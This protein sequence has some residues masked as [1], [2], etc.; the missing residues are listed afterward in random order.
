[1]THECQ[2]DTDGDGDCHRCA[3][4]P[5]GCPMTHEA[6]ELTAEELAE[7]IKTAR[8]RCDW[9]PADSIGHATEML[10]KEL[11]GAL[12]QVT[13]RLA[14]A[15]QRIE[16]TIDARDIVAER[17]RRWQKRAEAAERK[18]EAWET[19][20]EEAK[21]KASENAK[22]FDRL[23]YAEGLARAIARR[24]VCGFIKQR[25]AELLAAPQPRESGGE[26]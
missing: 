12:E 21:S 19:A 9:F 18:A 1:M 15:E 24:E 2:H 14:A 6:H 13:A 20:V 17:F 4:L 26:G 25:A 7:L 10:L 23:R 5:G 11:A 22:Q 8:G 3:H 16:E